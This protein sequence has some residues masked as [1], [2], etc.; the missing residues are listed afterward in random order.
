MYKINVVVSG[1]C[2]IFFYSFWYFLPGTC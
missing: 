2:K 1:I